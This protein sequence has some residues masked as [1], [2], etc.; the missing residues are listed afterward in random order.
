MNEQADKPPAEAKPGAGPAPAKK[1]ANLFFIIILVAAVIVAAAGGLVLASVLTGGHAT[2]PESRGTQSVAAAP[3]YVFIPFGT[4]VVNLAEEKLNRYMKVTISLQV[5]RESAEAVERLILTERT[6]V[7]KDWI[8]TCLSDKEINDVKG[9]TNINR[10]RRE[11][12]SGFNVI[13]AQY[14][15]DRIEAVFFEELNVQ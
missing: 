1:G 15:K 3:E 4:A 9:A 5:S 14:G 6:A 11:V 8:I 10:L 2:K 7:F 13:L 12:A